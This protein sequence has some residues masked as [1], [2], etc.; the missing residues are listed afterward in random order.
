MYFR[1]AELFAHRKLDNCNL[2]E[3][4]VRSRELDIRDTL[5]I[6]YS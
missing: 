4:K 5:L 6:E 3:W 2:F 1:V